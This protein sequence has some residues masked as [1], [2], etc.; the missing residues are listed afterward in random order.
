[1][2]AAAAAQ[3]GPPTTADG[4]AD[5][6]GLAAQVQLVTGT[7]TCSPTAI[8]LVFAG[9]HVA[10]DTQP[11]DVVRLRLPTA[12]ASA[13]HAALERDAAQLDPST[14]PPP[15]PSQSRQSPSSAFAVAAVSPAAFVNG[16]FACFSRLVPGLTPFGQPSPTRAEPTTLFT[17]AKIADLLRLV[18]ANLS[19]DLSSSSPS[20]ATPGP[21]PDPSPPP[22]PPPPALHLFGFSK[23]AVVLTRLIEEAAAGN[24]LALLPTLR[25]LHFVDAGLNCP[26]VVK[27]RGS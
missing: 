2:A 5:D 4:D 24:V 20:A 14:A 6:G 21:D 11:A 3:P 12:Q 22:P 19:A 15:P 9:D 10:G 18:L 26:G 8:A 17:A 23:G 7:T 16:C 13:V 27:T 1:M 25:S